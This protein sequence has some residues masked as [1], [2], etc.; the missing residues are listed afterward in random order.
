MT[1]ASRAGEKL[2]YALKSFNIRVVDLVCAD[3]GS[4]AGGFVDCLLQAGAK[5]VYAVETGY[6][7]LDWKLRNNERVV[8]M[9]RQNAMHV[10][11]PEKVDFMSIDT[12]WTRLDKIIPNALKNLKENGHII[13]LVKPHYEAEPKML[14]KGKL[15]DK[16]I[17]EV[18]N[19][20]KN[21]LRELHIEILSETES[22]VL[23]DKG[24]NKEY[25]FHIK[26]TG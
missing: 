8:V 12:S 10:E 13:A 9:E 15:L 23:G 17:P 4:S 14:R 25:L 5:K 26:K 3:F 19:S 24:K 1:Y 11:L 2:E 7:V 18:L 21:R 6:G 22:P 20:V 16:F